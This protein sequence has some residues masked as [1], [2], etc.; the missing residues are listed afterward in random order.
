[1]SSRI[2]TIIPWVVSGVGLIVMFGWFIDC[3]F[4]VQISSSYTSMK[5]ITALLFFMCGFQLMNMRNLIFSGYVKRE[6]KYIILL[7][8]SFL[9]I[10]ISTLVN[11]IPNIFEGLL[12][13]LPV[14][15]SYDPWTTI[16]Y[17]PSIATVL[18]FAIISISQ[19]LIIFFRNKTSIVLLSS[20]L[21]LNFIGSLAIIG[22]IFNLPT[23]FYT[24]IAGGGM[25]IHSAILFSLIGILF[26]YFYRELKR[27]ASS[28]A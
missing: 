10:L 23:L 13:T 14:N 9:I 1:M 4:I 27:T 12:N 24:K 2:K 18:S 15:V 20:G 5:F 8:I 7:T 17:L 3:R 26:I 25:A 28:P 21:I 19:I 16:P 6:T 11:V 22:Y